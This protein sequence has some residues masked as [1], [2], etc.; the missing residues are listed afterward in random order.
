MYPHVV[1]DMIFHVI[2][3]VNCGQPK[4]F[5][6]NLLISNNQ[7]EQI[8][9]SHHY[10]LEL[11]NQ[12]R[13]FQQNST[14][15]FAFF[16]KLNKFFTFTWSSSHKTS[17]CNNTAMRVTE[18]L[19]LKKSLFPDNYNAQHSYYQLMYYGQ[20]PKQSSTSTDLSGIFLLQTIPFEHSSS[21][22]RE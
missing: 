4:S 15:E 17:T 2:R 18:T 11:H 10:V 6:Q 12:H 5:M 9:I 13:Q 21:G 20:F 16:E 14:A 19:I 3:L 1:L 7:W 22:T 8:E